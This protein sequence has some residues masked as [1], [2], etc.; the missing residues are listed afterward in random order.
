MA[1]K[2]RLE[3]GQ[4]EV[5]DDLM[6]DILR[7]KTAAD[8]IRIAFNLWTST[9]DMLLVHLR[10]THPDWNEEKIKKEVARRL[11]HGGHLIC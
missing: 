10:K 8:R 6:A 7:A 9:R 3:P 1:G 5:V 4:I 11:S 2:I